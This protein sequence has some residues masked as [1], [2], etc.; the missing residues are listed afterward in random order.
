MPNAGPTLP[1]QETTAVRV[2]V[3]SISFSVSSSVPP[4]ISS[5]YSARKI[6][7]LCCTSREMGASFSR[8]T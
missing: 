7:V 2:D 5:R 4:R 6:K 1:V 3:K 8:T